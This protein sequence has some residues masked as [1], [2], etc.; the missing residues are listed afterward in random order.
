MAV[1]LCV[2]PA[3]ASGKVLIF[4]EHPEGFFAHPDRL[5]YVSG[6]FSPEYTVSLRHMEWRDWGSRRSRGRGRGK[7]CAPMSP[8]S[9]GRV[10]AIAKGRFS[11]ESG[12]RYY[13]TLVVKQGNV[14]T[15]L[16]VNGE[17]C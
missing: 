13:K 11:S 8:C 15:K 14:K 10:T 2:F 9:V 5:G 4:S 12:G 3:S 1:A 17:V 7:L 6:E 16:C